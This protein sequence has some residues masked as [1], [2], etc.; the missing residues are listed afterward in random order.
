LPRSPD[1]AWGYSIAIRIF[2][3]LGVLRR[4]DF[5]TRALAFCVV[6]TD[7]RNYGILTTGCDAPK[8]DVIVI[9]RPV[10]RPVRY[11]QMVGR[12]LRGEKNGGTAIRT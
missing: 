1:T 10:F 2:A 3:R 6:T 12:G 8:T 5:A 9:S 11:M 4:D 7:K